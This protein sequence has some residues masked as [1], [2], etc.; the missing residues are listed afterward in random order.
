MLQKVIGL[1]LAGAQIHR[2]LHC[3][4]PKSIGQYIENDRTEVVDLLFAASSLPVMA[5]DEAAAALLPGQ[6]LPAQPGAVDSLLDT[7]GHPQG[8]STTPS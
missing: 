7:T 3:G 4:P 1:P 6:P 5:P 8:D 2:S